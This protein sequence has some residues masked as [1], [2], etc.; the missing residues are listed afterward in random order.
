MRNGAERRRI[1]AGRSSLLAN[2]PA[3]GLATRTCT[4]KTLALHPALT[5]HHPLAREE[6]TDTSRRALEDR[7]ILRSHSPR[8]VPPQPVALPSDLMSG[9]SQA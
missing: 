7:R 9:Q 1:V 3:V 8:A 2:T 6:I 4:T 5:G